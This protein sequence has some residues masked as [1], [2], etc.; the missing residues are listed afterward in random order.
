MTYKLLKDRLSQ[1][2]YGAVKNN[3]DG[4]VTSFIFEDSPH[5]R[6]YQD[7]LAEGNTPEPADEP[8]G[9]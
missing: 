7:W 4:S 5:Y 8:Q 3:D 2:I 9:E 1:E 6:M